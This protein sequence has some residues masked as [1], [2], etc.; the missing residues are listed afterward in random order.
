MSAA[1]PHLAAT[2]VSV[3]RSDTNP[4]RALPRDLETDAKIAELLLA[5]TDNKGVTTEQIR[6]AVGDHAVDR[7]GQWA[8][9]LG[10]LYQGQNEAGYPMPD[11]WL[12]SQ[13]GRRAAVNRIDMWKQTKPYAGKEKS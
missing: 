5:D 10:W 11:T 13:V 3:V 2:T 6:K 8:T 4:L 12:L 7:I 9:R 1:N